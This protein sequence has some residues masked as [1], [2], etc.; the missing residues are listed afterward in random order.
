MG[1]LIDTSVLIGHERGS[2]DLDRMQEERIGERADVP[3]FL[4]VIT[5][6]ELLHGTHRARTRV[7]RARRRA[8]VEGVI[9]AF[10]LLQIDLMTARAHAELGAELTGRGTPIG[11]H[12]LWIAAT[13]IAR[14]LD[15]V[16]LNA[17]EFERVPG[18]VVEVWG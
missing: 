6:S 11:T 12:D 10:P 2:R 7:Q 1:V 14:G 8:F 15:L 17:R 13:A 3:F 16:T 4:S 5:V 9:D 18:L